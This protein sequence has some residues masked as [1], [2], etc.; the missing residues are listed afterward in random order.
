M[1]FHLQHL[2]FITAADRSALR[3]RTAAAAVAVFGCA[4]AG[5]DMLMIIYRYYMTLWW[6]L[7]AWLHFFDD[8]M[9]RTI[10]VI[11]PWIGDIVTIEYE[12]CPMAHP[13]LKHLFDPV[14]DEAVENHQPKRPPKSPHQFHGKGWSLEAGWLSHGHPLLGIPLLAHWNC[15][16]LSQFSCWL[17]VSTN[18]PKKYEGQLGWWNSQLNG[19]IEKMI[20]TTNQIFILW[21]Y[22]IACL[23]YNRSKPHELAILLWSNMR[24]APWRIQCSNICLIQLGM[25]LLKITSQNDHQNHLTSSMGRAGRWKL[26]DSLTVIPC[27]ESRYWLTGTVLDSLSFHAGWWFQ[28]TLRKNMKVSWDDE[29]P[30]W[31]EKSKMFQTTNQHGSSPMILQL[32]MKTHWKIPSQNPSLLWKPTWCC[33]LRSAAPVASRNFPGSFQRLRSRGLSGGKVWN[34]WNHLG[35][36]TVSSFVFTRVI[37]KLWVN[38]SLWSSINSR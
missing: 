2:I 24:S 9:V 23:H 37:N 38:S 13:M 6:Y 21:W 33:A 26:G 18:P 7:I 34:K 16:W 32:G 3:L 8:C 36:T 1:W 30:N 11:S 14:G 20:Q 10:T 25:K 12:E 35:C 5:G 19:K 27:W 4:P 22:L 28:Q 31:M 15:P 17:V 29:I